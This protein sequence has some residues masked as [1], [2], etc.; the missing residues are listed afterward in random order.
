[1]VAGDDLNDLSSRPDLQ[2]ERFRPCVEPG[3]WLSG[4]LGRALAESFPNPI[5][6]SWEDDP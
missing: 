4:L 1:M 5:Y 2:E 3:Y 6:G